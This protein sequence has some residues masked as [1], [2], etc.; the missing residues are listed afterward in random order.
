MTLKQLLDVL[1]V[2]M[3]DVEITVN[4]EPD[5]YWDIT[6]MSEYTNYLDAKVKRVSVNANTVYIVLFDKN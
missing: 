4:T 1:D 5:G 2:A 6:T 3:K